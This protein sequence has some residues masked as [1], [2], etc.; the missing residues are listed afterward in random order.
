MCMRRG[1]DEAVE[2]GITRHSA[3]S[4][5][6]HCNLYTIDFRSV[7]WWRLKE[8]N[9]LGSC[10]VVSFSLFI[11]P[12]KGFKGMK[13]ARP[14]QIFKQFTTRAALCRCTRHLWLLNRLDGP[15]IE[16]EATS[17]INCIKGAR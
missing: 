12:R 6:A 14:E 8:Y 1:W 3:R 7:H 17:E 4:S 2:V 16:I 11:L 10:F 15:A 13:L 9:G 5:V